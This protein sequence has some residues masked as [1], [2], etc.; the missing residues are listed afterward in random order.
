MHPISCPLLFLI[1]YLDEAPSGLWANGIVEETNLRYQGISAPHSRLQI[2]W[3]ILEIASGNFQLSTRQTRI[4]MGFLMSTIY[5]LVL[6]VNPM[7]RILVRWK[8]FRQYLEILCHRNRLYLDNCTCL[9]TR[10]FTYFSWFFFWMVS[11]PQKGR[12]KRPKVPTYPKTTRDENIQKPGFSRSQKLESPTVAWCVFGSSIY[13]VIVLQYRIC[14]IQI[15]IHAKHIWIHNLYQTNLSTQF[16]WHKSKYTICII[17]YRSQYAQYTCKYA[18]R[19]R[20]IWIHHTP[21]SYVKCL[22]SR[23]SDVNSY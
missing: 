20:H 15:S 12:Q 14:M 7:G 8:D 10:S 16:V 17:S 22:S 3:Q 11:R 9:S 5:D 1:W 23:D 6:I 4:L 21:M 13:N 18:I 2:G 19:T